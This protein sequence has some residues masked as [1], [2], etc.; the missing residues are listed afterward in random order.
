MIVH[1]DYPPQSPKA[2][3]VSAYLAKRAQI[4]DSEVAGLWTIE[5]G[6]SLEGATGQ[7]AR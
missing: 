7:K 1:T 2:I 5:P 4:A 3:E 6:L